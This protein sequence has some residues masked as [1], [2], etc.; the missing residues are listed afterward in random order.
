MGKLFGTDG[1]RGKANVYPMT[2]E[3]ALKVGRVI[4]RHFGNQKRSAIVFGRDTR[5]SGTML[6]SAIVSGCCSVGCDALVCG[7]LPTPGVAFLSKKLGAAAGVVVSASHNPYYDNGIKIFDGNGYKLSETKEELIEELILSDKPVELKNKRVGETG[8]R[9]DLGDGEKRYSDFLIG[10]VPET[11][12]FDDMTVVLDCANGATYRVA[13]KIFAG[14]GASV[15]ALFSGPDGK[16]INHACG[17]QH[18]EYLSNRV[19]ELKA[20][21]GLAFDGDGDRLIAVDENGETL[22]GDKILAICARYFKKNGVLDNNT[23]VSTV[24]SNMGLGEALRKMDISHA[25]TGVGDRYVTEKMLD[26]GAVLG[27]EDSGHI[28]FL[29]H[30]TT[31][32]G[33]LTALKL[34]EIMVAEDKPL[35]ELTSVMTV[36][37]QVLV[38]VDVT[39]KPPLDSIP[40]IEAAIRDVENKLA[41]K[42]RVL[43]R[44]SGTQPQC[45]VMVEGPTHDDIKVFSNRIAKAIQNSI[46]S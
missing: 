7:V 42:G 39:H 27:G 15:E 34:L 23:V 20:Q 13:P 29:G 16:N 14:L 6:E 31:G 32:D 37:P 28:V 8:Q 22:T 17:S 4:G 5:L 12:H 9:I 35:S 43:V 24:M 2:P 1:I 19:Q 36:F 33:I 21:I 41:G 46:G 30:Q 10:S 44:Y 25:I 11:F 40:E 45:R 18:P 38:N 26:A 3:M